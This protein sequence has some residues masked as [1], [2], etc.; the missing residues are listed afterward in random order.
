MLSKVA[1]RL[2]S[3]EISN[4]ALEKCMKDHLIDSDHRD[5]VRKNLIKA[6]EGEVTNYL[7]SNQQLTND[8]RRILNNWGS[9]IRQFGMDYYYSDDRKAEDIERSEILA[10]SENLIIAKFNSYINE[11][12]GTI[13]I[14]SKHN[15]FRI[16]DFIEKMNLYN[17]FRVLIVDLENNGLNP[18]QYVKK[19]KNQ[20]HKFI[21]NMNLLFTEWEKLQKFGDSE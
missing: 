17:S 9:L 13:R 11:T 6:T 10:E 1:E 14:D 12:I 21:R 5:F 16:S 19:F 18:E 3:L 8:Y 15:K 4:V 2:E 20:V 7:K